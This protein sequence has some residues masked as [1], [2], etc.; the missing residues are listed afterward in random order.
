MGIGKQAVFISTHGSTGDVAFLSRIAQGFLRQGYDIRLLLP[1]YYLQQTRP[2]LESMG[3]LSHAAA[4][5]QS[6][7]DI[8]VNE[9]RIR[10]IEAYVRLVGER[11]AIQFIVGDESCMGLILLARGAS[12]PYFQASMMPYVP[13]RSFVVARPFPLYQKFGW[14]NALRWN[15]IQKQGAHR[16]TLDT[17]NLLEK[18]LP[19]LAVKWL[20]IVGREHVS[21]KFFDSYYRNEVNHLVSV[22]PAILPRPPD[23]GE[24]VHCLAY[25][26]WDTSTLQ[27]TPELERFVLN[28]KPPIFLGFGSHR[29]IR[30]SGPEGKKL[31]RELAGAAARLGERLV[32]HASDTAWD[33]AARGGDEPPGNVFCVGDVSHSWLF[34]RCS[35]IACHGGYGTIHTALKSHKP[36]VIYPW[37]TDQFLWAARLAQL[38]AAAPYRTLYRALSADAFSRDLVWIR[39]HPSVAL[40]ARELGQV[41]A[42]EDNPVNHVTT[43]EETLARQA[44]EIFN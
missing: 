9:L 1:P 19:K 21:P 30:F 31:L 27:P 16:F 33:E 17:L 18:H 4:L 10:G 32:F 22:N 40:R 34:P 28:G 29:N 20:A 42:K 43:I 3:L 15:R 37:I 24:N 44:P 13:T 41:L 2:V 25:T 11:D 5:F 36:L 12:I 38:G 23:W 39:E 35:L 26:Q 7:P 14:I 8:T 6:A